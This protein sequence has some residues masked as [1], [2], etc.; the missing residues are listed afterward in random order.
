MII[1]AMGERCIERYFEK[2]SPFDQNKVLG[3][4]RKDTDKTGYGGDLSFE[5]DHWTGWMKLP[6]AI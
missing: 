5:R 3:M 4:E 2:Y 1:E 6:P